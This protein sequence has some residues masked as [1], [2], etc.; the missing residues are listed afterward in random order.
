MQVQVH[1]VKTHVSWTHQT[2]NSVQ[3]GAILIQQSTSFV[4]PWEL[5]AGP[6]EL[7]LARE[8]FLISS[9][10]VLMPTIC[11]TVRRTPKFTPE[12]ASM[13]LFGPGV[14]ELTNVNENSAANMDAGRKV[15]SC[16]HHSPRSA[17]FIAAL[18]I[19]MLFFTA[20]KQ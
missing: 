16:M 12:M 7:A 6:D 14:I 3:V 17:A 9:K 15:P 10:P 2:H 11:G 18:S 19:A 5:D 20:L 4:Q 8:F 1:H 13:M